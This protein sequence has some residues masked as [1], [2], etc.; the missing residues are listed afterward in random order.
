MRTMY[1]IPGVRVESGK[2]GTVGKSG[3]EK[4]QYMYLPPFFCVT[5]VTRIN[6]VTQREGLRYYIG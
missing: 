2:A 3:Q 5:A 1:Q 4:M 6:T